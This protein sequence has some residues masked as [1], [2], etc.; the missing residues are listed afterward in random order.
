LC[1]IHVEKRGKKRKSIRERKER[2][3]AK[4]GTVI[5]RRRGGVGW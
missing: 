2:D 4:M 1:S 5:D 3:K